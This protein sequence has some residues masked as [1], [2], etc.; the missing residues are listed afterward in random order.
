M[1]CLA[2]TATAYAGWFH[3]GRFGMSVSLGFFIGQTCELEKADIVG[4]GG[5]AFILYMVIKRLGGISAFKVAFYF[6]T[7]M[8]IFQFLTMV[9]SV[10]IIGANA[11][12]WAF[13]AC[14]CCW[15]LS[16]TNSVMISQLAMGASRLDGRGGAGFIQ[17]Q[18]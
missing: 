10:S 16:F 15:V 5:L 1:F 12:G 17:M 13:Y 2:L 7:I 6:S 14:L 9:V 18:D 4:L 3:Y 8:G 11:A